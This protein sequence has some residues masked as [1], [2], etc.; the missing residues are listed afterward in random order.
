M[1]AVMALIS[2]PI[3]CALD[4]QGYN[5]GLLD[6]LRS[7]RSSTMSSQTPPSNT[8]FIL[9]HAG[10]GLH[11]ISKRTTSI[12]S[13]RAH[14]VLI[15]I[16]AVSLNYRDFAMSAAFYPVSRSPNRVLGSDMAG[17]VVEVG[18]GV[19]A[20]E[21]KKGDRVTANFSQSHIFGT[22]TGQS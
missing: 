3:L 6:H 8:A 16:N 9:P 11:T 5:L 21:F 7:N 20:E 12:P 4:P 17:E 22:R 10:G 18:E 2:L 1:F 14:E 13:P 15:K 19:G